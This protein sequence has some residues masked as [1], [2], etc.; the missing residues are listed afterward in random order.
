MVSDMAGQTVHTDHQ[1]C[2]LSHATQHSYKVWTWLD[3]FSSVS[4]PSGSSGGHRGWFSRDPLPVFSVGGHWEQFWRGQGCP[5]FNVSIQH[6]QCQPQYCT[7]S[8]VP[9]RTVLERL[10]WCVTC[11]NHASFQLVTVAFKRFLWTHKEG[12]LAR[13]PVIGLV[14]QVEDMESQQAGP[15]CSQSL[16]LC[17]KWKIWRVNKQVHVL[18]PER[19]MEG[20]RDLYSLNLL[21]KL[22]VLHRQI[23][24][25]LALLRNVSFK[26]KNNDYLSVSLLMRTQG[27]YIGNKLDLD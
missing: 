8:Q 11:P 27:A 15:C 25:N 1:T 12:D 3:Q 13:Q 10:L 24:Y 9:W 26:F 17:S 19:R 22:K 20:T 14:L 18:H 6:F 21:V 4:W 2:F 5:L 16:V 23:L 7:P